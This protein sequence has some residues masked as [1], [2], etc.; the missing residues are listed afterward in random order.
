MSGPLPYLDRQQ[1]LKQHARTVAMSCTA[2]YHA[3]TQCFKYVKTSP[4]N[5]N[6]ILFL[7]MNSAKLPA[8]NFIRFSRISGLIG[9][10]R[11]V[12]GAVSAKHHPALACDCAGERPDRTARGPFLWCAQRFWIFVDKGHRHR[13]LHRGH[14]EIRPDLFGHPQRRRLT[15]DHSARNALPLREYAWHLP[16][17]DTDPQLG[18]RPLD[19]TNDQQ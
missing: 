8:G 5:G 12:A 17:Y 2:D 18:D 9:R 10:H 14:A 19:P 11:T 15:T 3:I 4:K 13:S 1:P 16:D 6:K 7:N